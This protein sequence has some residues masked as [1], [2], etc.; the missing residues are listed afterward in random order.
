MNGEVFTEC[1]TKFAF[2]LVLHCYA[3]QF[4]KKNFRHYVTQWEIKPH[5]FLRLVPAS[6]VCLL[7]VLI[8]FMEGKR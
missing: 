1:R 3:L 2:A 7:G 4:T 8:D 6:G 5:A